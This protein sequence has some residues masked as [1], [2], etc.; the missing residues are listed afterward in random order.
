MCGGAEIRYDRCSRKQAEALTE[1]AFSLIPGEGGGE[2]QVAALYFILLW[3]RQ[4]W[5][6]EKNVSDLIA[7][8]IPAI[9]KEPYSVQF[10]AARIREFYQIPSDHGMIYCDMTHLYMENQR[11]EVPWIYKFMNLE[12]L[13]KRQGVKKSREQLY[14]Y[15]SHLLHMLQ[16]SGQIVNR[17]QAGDNLLA[18]VPLL[19]EDQCHEIVLELIRAL[20]I[21]EY[22]VSKYI[23]PCLGQMFA[24]L[25]Q[26][27]RDYIL[28]QLHRLCSAD[29]S[30]TVIAVLET[31]GKILHNGSGK[32]SDG[33]RSRAEGILCIGMADYRDE[34]TQEA[35]Y[36]TGYELFGSRSFTPDEK[37]RYFSELARK[38]L[39][40]LN[41]ERLGLYVYFNGAA[42]NRIYRFVFENGVLTEKGFSYGGS[43]IRPEATGYGAVYYL[44]NVLKDDGQDIK[45]DHRLCGIRECDLGYQQK[46]H[47]AGCE[48]CDS[49]R[50]RRLCL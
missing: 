34:I 35:F 41:W 14:Q 20:E 43:L 39:T 44:E 18:I 13:K 30:R 38:I 32:L 9:K 4:G 16:F 7:E 12:I 48:S 10:L 50:T 27:E 22:A 45:G 37:Q 1:F 15:A 19:S 40:L 31:A 24:L 8:G 3:M 6:P 47:G 46:G 42:L 25:G 5:K 11:S 49:F 21:E 29:H 23:P 17:L 36:I 26:G 33:E 2:S 28:T